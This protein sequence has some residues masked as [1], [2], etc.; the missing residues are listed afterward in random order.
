MA[1]VAL[2]LFVPPAVWSVWPLFQARFLHVFSIIPWSMAPFFLGFFLLWM[3]EI[4]QRLRSPGMKIPLQMPTNNGF[5]MVSKWCRI[6]H[7]Q[8]GPSVWSMALVFFFFFS[9]RRW[10]LARVR[11]SSWR[12]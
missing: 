2:F 6:S 12:S 1:L 9:R 10:P 3:N 8:Y 5:P 11:R 7:P 4:L